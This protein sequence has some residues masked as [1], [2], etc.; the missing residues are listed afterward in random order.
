VAG[1][2]CRNGSL[3]LGIALVDCGAATSGAIE[4]TISL[5]P[6]LS[7]FGRL[8][9]A[10]MDG[11]D[12]AK[13]AGGTVSRLKMTA[14]AAPTT[15]KQVRTAIVMAFDRQLSIFGKSGLDRDSPAHRRH[16]PD[17]AGRK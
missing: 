1:K 14:A 15:R 5:S 4:A 3:S 10:M 6:L 7:R 17:N 8:S 9:C 12:A 16:H 2:A 11:A 13:L